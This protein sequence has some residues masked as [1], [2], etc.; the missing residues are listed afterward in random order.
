MKALTIIPKKEGTLKLREVDEP[1]LASDD[2]L[3]EMLMIGICGTD[4]E[5]A[6]GHYGE[7]PKGSEY[8]IIGHESLG[9]VLKAPNLSPFKVGDLVVGFVRRP[10]PVPCAHCAVDE[11][12]MCENELYTERG[13]K[14]LH[15][16][17]S[18]H[19]RL[20]EKYALKLDRS[21]ADVG[22]LIEP[23]SVVA[24][25]WDQTLK[26]AA[27]SKVPPKTVLVTGA[28][29]VGLLAAMIGIQKGLEV[30]VLDQ[31]KEG[32]KVDLVKALGA[33]YHSDLD[34][35]ENSKME[36]DLSFECTGVPEVILKLFEHIKSDGI[37]CLTGVS[38]GGS[39][40][41]ID[42][43]A[44]NL[45]MVLQNE[46]IFGSVNAN[47]LHYELAQRYLLAADLNWLKKLISRRVPLSKW[48]D[49]FKKQKTDIKVVLIS[50]SPP[51][52]NPH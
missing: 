14:G 8:L 22:V 31:I 26:I 10:D 7:A 30:H 37:L 2:L 29:P 34:S 44:L 15:G 27:R 48:E 46:L 18:D 47:R 3:C 25:A 20:E 45:K 41:P 6:H 38:S 23:T 42:I 17:A 4:A 49:G 21:L 24:K 36:F 51:S 16:Y 40:F 52:A 13:I 43:G 1:V 33:T 9:R 28:G 11:W 19:Y 39:N 32:P 50:E 12:D 35:L 5:I